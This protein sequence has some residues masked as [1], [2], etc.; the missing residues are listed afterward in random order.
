MSSDL[1]RRLCDA[2][3]RI[4]EG[5]SLMQEEVEVRV[6]PLK[7]EEA[8]G[9]PSI[10]DY[11]LLKG[12]EVMVEAVFKGY[13]GQAFTSTPRSFSGSLREVFDLDLSNPWNR[14][15]FI[16]VL[17]AVMA[18]LGLVDR[19]VHCRNDY[20]LVCGRELSMH[21]RERGA[22]RV[23]LIGYQPAML[24]SL[25]ESGFR[26]RAAD[27]DPDN[28]GKVKFGV[29]I[30]APDTDEDI[31]SWSEAS[32]VTGSVLVNG[33]LDNV[34]A[35]YRDKIILYGVSCAAPAKILGLK[36]WCTSREKIT[37]Y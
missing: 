20:P 19:T 13:R 26:V 11:A 31:I 12:R 14:T 28:I 23:G 36:R 22:S 2:G 35:K 1:L 24:K 8:I 10:G 27:A 6:R 15:V 5:N 29:E 30:E 9:K 37:Q 7:A 21:L 18:Y 17:N 3:R 33:S 32:L 4:V 16:A 34:I 25:V